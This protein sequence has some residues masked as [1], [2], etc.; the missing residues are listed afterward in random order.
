MF[1]ENSCSLWRTTA[2]LLCY[3]D[4]PVSLLSRVESSPILE[5]MLAQCPFRCGVFP[6]P[7]SV[8]LS[9]KLKMFLLFVPYTRTLHSIV[10]YDV[11][12]RS[13]YD[14]T[15]GLGLVP[16][17]KAQKIIGLRVPK[18]YRVRTNRDCGRNFQCTSTSTVLLLYY[19]VLPTTVQ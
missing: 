18:N 16:P 6:K 2:H 17:K 15:L 14:Q 9:T 19:S 12:C 13:T 10:E 7:F 4:V 3:K 8:F 5:E 1:R 11:Y